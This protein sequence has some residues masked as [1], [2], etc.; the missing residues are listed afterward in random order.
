MSSGGVGGGSGS[1]G[2]CITNYNSVKGQLTKGGGG[3][4]TK[5]MR[6]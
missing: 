5:I 3:T 6:N 4:I 1:G 2:A